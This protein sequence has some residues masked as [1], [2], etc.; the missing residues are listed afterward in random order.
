MR[1]ARSG[2]SQE[3]NDH[4]NVHAVVTDAAGS[5]WAGCR[6]MSSFAPASTE[7]AA[8]PMKAQ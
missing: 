2:T 6:W 8:A 7:M 4:S 1:A 3:Q 5:S